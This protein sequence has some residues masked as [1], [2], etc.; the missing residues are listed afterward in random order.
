MIWAG[1]SCPVIGSRCD[2]KSILILWKDGI[3]TWTA[4]SAIDSFEYK[5]LP[6]SVIL[7]LAWSASA[8]FSKHYHIFLL[9][10]DV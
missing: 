2:E 10:A 7:P 9:F 5:L 6:L 3:A 8:A 4:L 1:Q